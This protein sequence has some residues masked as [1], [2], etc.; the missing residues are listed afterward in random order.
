[1]PSCN[2]NVREESTGV[3]WRPSP[4]IIKA[5]GNHPLDHSAVVGH[6]LSRSARPSDD[7]LA[8]ILREGHVE[9]LNF[10]HVYS[11]FAFE[12]YILPFPLS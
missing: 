9:P 10:D 3:K 6:M 7:R 5:P 12:D 4:A 2:R 11:H 1:M 8:I